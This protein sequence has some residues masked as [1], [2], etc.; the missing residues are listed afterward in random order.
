MAE[1]LKKERPE[2]KVLFMSGYSEHAGVQSSQVS[3]QA[4]LTKP[5]SIATLIGKVRE[6]LS[7]LPAS[8]ASEAEKVQL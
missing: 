2:L 1:R 3:P 7:G 5:F 8:K 6:A 4:I